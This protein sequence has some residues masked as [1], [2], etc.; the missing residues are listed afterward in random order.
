MTTAWMVWLEGILSFD[1]GCQLDL[2]AMCWELCLVLASVGRL[3]LL[4][5]SL[6]WSQMQPMARSVA[7]ALK[8]IRLGGLWVLK[9]DQQTG[10]SEET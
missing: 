4:I 6:E 2:L 7:R 10:V 1:A 8:E 9:S 3:G 5:N